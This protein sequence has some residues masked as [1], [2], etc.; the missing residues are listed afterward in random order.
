MKLLKKSNTVPQTITELR[1]VVFENREIP[2]SNSVEFLNPKHPSLLTID[3]V[4]INKKQFNAAVA[5]IKE[6]IQVDKKIVIF[7]DYDVDGICATA[8]L[9]QVLFSLY[10]QKHPKGLNH[11][12][13]F[14]PH[15]EKHGYGIT[16]KAI[17]EIVADLKP[18]VIITVDNGIVAHEPIKYAQ[19][20]GIQVILT[21]HHEPEVKNGKPLYPPADCIVHTTQLCGATVG[22]MLA[23]AL[24][25]SQAEELLD[26]AA[27]ATIADQVP[28]LAANRSF[29]RH[30]LQQL[31]KSTN[32]GITELLKSAVVTQENL[33]ETTVGFVLA[34]R[35]NAMGRL[36]HGLDALRLLCTQNKKQAQD[37][38]ELLTE[39]NVSR[40]DLTKQMTESAKIQAAES[41]AEHLIIVESDSFHEGILGLIAGGLAEEFHKPAIAIT[42]GETVAKASARSILGVNIIEILREI[43]E[44]LLTVGGHPMAAGFSFIPSNLHDIKTKLYQLAKKHI[45]KE[46]L[47]KSLLVDCE[48]APQLVSVSTITALSEFAPY[49]MKNP[50]PIFEI[51]NLQ[52]ISVTAIGKQSEHIKITVIDTSE[53]SATAFHCLGWRMGDRLPEVRK[54]ATI[55]IVGFLEINE[56]KNKKYPQIILKDFII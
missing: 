53:S 51:K 50:Q 19:D 32:V 28:L 11:P 24:A 16:S 4:G 27:V 35:I 6:S 23:H 26:L 25:K 18:A 9:W 1:A 33:N 10:R 47:E 43:Q 2:T 8:I 56:W 30:G 49:G 17:D 39:T 31:R 20:L 46:N 48:I 52:V 54:D 22:W 15:R 40:Q 34:P 45:T 38:A 29:A 3:A 13:P 37:L 14:I 42:V 7:G 5:L 44:D 12:V 36:E 21:D 41:E 55:T